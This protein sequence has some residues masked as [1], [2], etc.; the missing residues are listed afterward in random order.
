MTLALVSCFIALAFAVTDPNA[1]TLT[2]TGPSGSIAPGT[3][4]SMA[5]T[6]TNSIVNKATFDWYAPGKYPAG[7]IAFT[8]VDTTPGDGFT[9]TQTV[10]TGGPWEVVVTFANSAGTPLWTDTA[11]TTVTN[12]VFVGVVVQ[13]IPELPLIGTVGGSIAM[14]AGLGYKLKRKK[15]NA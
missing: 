10:N 11:T 9:S 15:F 13:V 5:A 12:V 14:L 7:P 6:T 3:A 1:Y 4:V 2:K 8:T